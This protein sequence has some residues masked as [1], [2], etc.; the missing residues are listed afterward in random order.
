MLED[1]S[2][3]FNQIVNRPPRPTHPAG[4]P[5]NEDLAARHRVVPV[6]DAA[7]PLDADPSGG[8]QSPEEAPRATRI[9]S[10][11]GPGEVVSPRWWTRGGPGVHDA[12]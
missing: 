4:R 2:N 5:S 1:I 9:V 6:P 8:G 11:P 3:P 7:I 12:E 10:A